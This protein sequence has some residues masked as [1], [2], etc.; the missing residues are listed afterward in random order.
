MQFSSERWL[1]P[2]E[3]AHNRVGGLSWATWSGYVERDIT[4][5]F[6]KGW[7]QA[8]RHL[9]WLYSREGGPQTSVKLVCVLSGIENSIMTSSYVHSL[10]CYLRSNHIVLT[11]LNQCSVM[12]RPVDKI[13]CLT[14]Q[15]CHVTVHLLKWRPYF[16]IRLSSTSLS[17]IY[18]IVLLYSC[19]T[20]SQSNSDSLFMRLD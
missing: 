9:V 15:W 7:T 12:R 1:F 8:N 20:M 2:H 10:G 17:D 11:R 5:A 6:Y 19:L 4:V 14:W 18:N 13:F 3:T 16:H